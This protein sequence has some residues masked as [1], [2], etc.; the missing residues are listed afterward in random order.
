M[1][2]LIVAII[3]LIVGFIFLIKG[4]ELFRRRKR[5]CGEASAGTIDHH[6][7]DGRC[8]GNQSAGVCSQCDGIDYE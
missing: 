3:T 2:E 6:R 5:K 1:R 8:N 4:A 7:Y